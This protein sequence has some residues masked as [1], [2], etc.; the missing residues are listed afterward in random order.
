LIGL[1]LEIQEQNNEK[2]DV[3]ISSRWTYVW[4]DELILDNVSN[5]FWIFWLQ[6]VGF[7]FL[8]EQH[9]WT[10]PFFFFLQMISPVDNNYLI[11]AKRQK[12]PSKIY[13]IIFCNDKDEEK[14]YQ[15][16]IK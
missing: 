2:F 5:A 16:K 11:L 10:I 15:N 14:N 1:N 8:F 9:L 6:Q 13:M 3:F 7:E 4:K 12:Y